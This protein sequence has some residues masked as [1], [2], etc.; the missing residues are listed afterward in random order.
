MKIS[1]KLKQILLILFLLM[2]VAWGNTAQAKMEEKNSKFETILYRKFSQNGYAINRNS[3]NQILQIIGK[4]SQSAFYFTSDAK[5]LTRED[6]FELKCNLKNNLE[7][8]KVDYQKFDTATSNFLNTN[9]YHQFMWLVDHFYIHSQELLN[10]KQTINNYIQEINE[11]YHAQINNYNSKTGEYDLLDEDDINTVQQLAIWHFT[12][13]G[14]QNDIGDPRTNLYDI[15]KLMITNS[16][17]S[18]KYIALSQQKDLQEKLS[19]MDQL[20]RFFIL[21]ADEGYVSY[22]LNDIRSNQRQLIQLK[23]F[24][25]TTINVVRNH[26]TYSYLAGPYQ[27]MDN[28]LNV[29]YA[30]ASIECTGEIKEG[31]TATITNDIDI[32]IK[33]EN[34]AY[35]V[36]TDQEGNVITDRLQVLER[37]K[38]SQQEF[39]IAAKNNVQNLEKMNLS[40][41]VRYEAREVDYYSMKNPSDTDAPIIGIQDKIEFQEYE[42]SSVVQLTTEVDFAL[43]QFVSAINGHE[44][45]NEDGAYIREPQVNT[46]TVNSRLEEGRVTTAIYS[47]T[48]DTMKVEYGDII[49]FTIRVYNEGGSDGYVSE[50]TDYLPPYLEFVNDEE[51]SSNGWKLQDSSNLRVVKTRKFAKIEGDDIGNAKQ[52]IIGAFDG[53]TLQYREV[54]LKCKVINPKEIDSITNTLTQLENPEQ[55]NVITENVETENTVSENNEVVNYDNPY[56]TDGETATVTD[57][58]HYAQNLWNRNEIEQNTIDDNSNNTIN[59]NVENIETQEQNLTANEEQIEPTQNTAQDEQQSIEEPVILITNIAE[60]T[61]FADEFGN[62][63]DLNDRDSKKANLRLPGDED[64]AKYQNEKLSNF[65]AYIPGQE[66]DDDFE[67][68]Q[69]K[70]FDLSLRQFVSQI[71]DIEITSRVPNANLKNLNNGTS[72]TAIYNHSKEPLKVDIGDTIILTIRV[73]NEGEMAAYCNELFEYLP[74][75]MEFLQDHEVN[76]KYEWEKAEGNIIKTRYLSKNNDEK[77]SGEN[78]RVNQIDKANESY[79]NYKDVKL[80]VKIIRTQEMIKKITC[81]GEISEAVNAQGEEVLDRDSDKLNIQLPEN[82][83]TY[84]DEFIQDSYVPGQEDDDDFEKLVIGDFDLALVEFISKLNDSEVTSRNPVVDVNNL[85][86]GANSTATYQ[87]GKETV[88]LNVGDII[89]YTVRIYNEGDVAGYAKEIKDKIP[90]G[91][92]YLP[93][94]E[95]NQTY[96]WKMRNE[97]GD[98]TSDLS[99]VSYV[100]TDY[101]SKNFGEEKMQEASTISK[102]PNLISAYDMALGGLPAY[103]EVKIAFQISKE[104]IHNQEIENQ[105]QISQN[106]NESG[107]VVKDRDSNSEEWNDGEDDQ[108]TDKLKVRFFDLSIDT[109]LEETIIIENGMKNRTKNLQEKNPI[110]IILDRKTAKT[111]KVQFHYKI[112]IQ[113]EGVLPGY[114]RKITATIPEGLKFEESE[115]LSWNIADDDHIVTEQMRDILLE[116]GNETAI[117]L[118]LTWENEKENIQALEMKSEILEEYN[119]FQS[120]D[121]HLDGNSASTAIQLTLKRDYR[122]IWIIISAIAVVVV[123]T[124]VILIKKLF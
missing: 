119:E 103:Q 15:N 67:K 36:V 102:N 64:L 57:I 105:V 85:N 56:G 55:N 19:A 124:G 115:N 65:D 71:N 90:N 48:K 73:Y 101:L 38:N 4:G 76:Q 16:S 66:D 49:T 122:M 51:N 91:L 95:T 121:I 54:K 72:T 22:N 74:A 59:Q 33:G 79:L 81:L 93:D 39:F 11:T 108:D 99:S 69:L 45:K 1:K 40:L 92:K 82:W 37:L 110:Q 43:R 107:E 6:H 77:G 97:N 116:S 86:N 96:R 32:L 94:H 53:N 9:R 27:M 87:T 12:A 23:T 68:L 29:D 35:Q 28:R 18:G 3:T 89:T 26:G 41:S 14:T 84:R 25:R 47:H 10:D 120:E 58:I 104:G 31:K 112:I 109:K 80:A 42:T 21:N 123:T 5:T 30:I 113:N 13:T 62:I 60:I 63:Q 83:E 88:V 52:R 70:S 118:I 50:I 2:F 106:E 46:S 117:D 8:A 78:R 61:E 34:G 7:D 24:D 100:T 111:A 75:Q 98:E 20:Y 17:I 44:L 114:A